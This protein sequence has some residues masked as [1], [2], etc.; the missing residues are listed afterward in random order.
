MQ[1]SA[2]DDSIVANGEQPEDGTQ[3]DLKGG[4]LEFEDD[5]R[6]ADAEYFDQFPPTYNGRKREAVTR[7]APFA[8][9]IQNN[10]HE[11]DGILP[12]PSG[13]PLPY[14]PS[15]NMQTSIYPGGLFNTP[16]GGRYS[17]LVAQ[18]L[19][20][21]CFCLY[22]TSVSKSCLVNDLISHE[23]SPLLTF[24]TFNSPHAFRYL[25]KRARGVPL[26]LVT[27]LC[28]LTWFRFLNS[29]SLNRAF[30]QAVFGSL[31]FE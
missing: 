22:K 29:I 28:F 12:F 17:K 27:L 6:Q 9:S 25:L 8:S 20:F 2:D 19:D 15:S 26:G 24:S 14:R 4:G 13:V 11:G 1:D 18:M 16:H 3:V 23:K 30:I 31:M 10:K 5:D 21:L 7:R